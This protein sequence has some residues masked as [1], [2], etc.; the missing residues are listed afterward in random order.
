M[1]ITLKD[2]YGKMQCVFTGALIKTY[3][4]MTL[5]LETSIEIRG[6]LRALPPKAHAPLDRELHADY[7]IVIGAAPGDKEA[8]SVRVQE[9]GDPQTL[10]DNRHL[11]LR[12]DVSSS[13]MKVRAALLEAFRTFFT[14]ERIREVTAP[15]MVQTQVEGGSTLFAFD[16]YGETA[17]LTQS[18][19]LYLETCLPSLGKVYAIQSSFRAEKAHTRR[20]LSEVSATA[21]RVPPS[22]LML[23]ST[24]TSRRSSTL[25]P[26]TTCSTTSRRRS[27]G[28]SISSSRT[29]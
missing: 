6:E 27:A 22:S 19:Q 11:V 29:P 16:Y 23:S 25:S 20:H 1:F 5:T 26:S 8:I 18:S 28:S 24:R 7:F 3:A 15:S 2:G 21:T 13:V 10:L 17:Y 4:A 9:G 12:G 14:E